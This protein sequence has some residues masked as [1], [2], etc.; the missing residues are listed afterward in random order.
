MNRKDVDAGPKPG[1]ILGPARRIKTVSVS[2]WLVLIPSAI[3]AGQGGLGPVPSR[4]SFTNNSIGFRYT[5]PRGMQD[6][7][8]TGRAEIEGRSVL[9]HA[10]KEL[11]LLL[12]LTSGPDNTTPA[13]QSLTI[14]TYPRQALSS[15]DDA[16]AEAK[17]SAWVAGINGSPGT[18]RSVVLSGQNFAVF[19]V[20]QREGTTK[21][22]AVIWTTIRK[23][24][25][26]SFAFVANSPQQ[27]TML[28]ES[29]KTLQFF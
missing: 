12:A 23:G 15:L 28:A 25:L 29:M 2:L 7:T 19:V 18:P 4:P 10:S 20:G 21:K 6:E 24:R 3:A 9:G 26:L 14:E 22:G 1:R 17:M 16:S 27:L 8:A 5:P 13:W 11:N